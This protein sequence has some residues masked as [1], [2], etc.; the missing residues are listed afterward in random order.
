V[1][2]NHWKNAFEPLVARLVKVAVANAREVDIDQ[3]VV[4]PELTPLDGALFEVRS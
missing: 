1:A 4:S 2:W 3:H